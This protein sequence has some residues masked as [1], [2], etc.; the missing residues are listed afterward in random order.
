MVALRSADTI[1]S[2]YQDRKKTWGP[3]HAAGHLLRTVYNGELPVVL[4]E[5]ETTERVAVANL[6]QTG[7]DQHAMR[8]A[9]VVPNITC[10]PMRG[11]VAAQTKAD[12]RRM[13]LQDFWNANKV[14]GLLRK[15]AR[16]LIGYSMSPVLLRPGKKGIPTW[17]IR[18]PLTAFPAPSPED[19]LVPPDTIFCIKR[20]LRWLEINYPEIAPHISRDRDTTVDTMFEVLQYIDEEQISLVAVGRD[21]GNGSV[22]HAM[23]AQ[24][25]NRANRPLVIVPGRITLDRLQGQFDQMIGMYET[26]AKLWALQLQAI[27]R[28]IFPETYVVS[29]DN[30]NA[31][32]VTPAD[33]YTGEIGTVAGGMIQ[34]I[35]VDPSFANMQVI[36]RLEA[37]QR[38]TGAVPAEFGGEAASNIR[39]GRRG[40]QVLSSTVDYPIQEHQEILAASLQEENAAA[41]DIALAWYPNTSR[42]FVL[43]YTRKPITYTAS[44]VFGETQAQFVDYSYAGSDTNGLVIE[45]GQRIG[46]GTLSKETFMGFD[47]MVKDP[48]AEMDRITLEGIRAAHLN[49]IQTQAA[50]PNGPYQPADLARLEEL[51]YTKNLPLFQAVQQ[52]QTEIQERQAAQ[53]GPAGM[54]PE[55]QPGLAMPGAPGAPT[56]T[57]GE[58]PPSMANLTSMLGDLRLQQRT[59]PAE[60]GSPTG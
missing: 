41:I 3:V 39:T 22:H 19:E 31:P 51:V 8:I 32:D 20:S 37:S 40:S 25:P 59:S 34:E 60:Q 54:P 2:L 11:G 6:I 47:P 58:S 45:G 55:G 27:Q 50:D 56:P 43:P 15:R 17:E 48:D 12:K 44:E 23:L 13:C 24:V 10:P 29:K 57:I 46:M 52:L 4:P 53:Q 21:D 38:N 9:S 28:G 49:A 1:A 7:L 14:P 42:T 33:P 30:G 36:D 18:D 16:H 35:R 5:L 26:Q